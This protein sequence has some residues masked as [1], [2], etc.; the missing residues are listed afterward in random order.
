MQGD[1]SLIRGNAAKHFSTP[2]Q[3]QGRVT[4]DS[5]LNEG[6]LA[7]LHYLRTA[8][9]DIVGPSAVPA[10]P[11]GGF[12][13]GLPS[14]APA[15]PDLSISKGRMY[16]DGILIENENDTTYWTQ[17]DAYLDPATDDD[18]PTAPYLV[19]VRVWERLVTAA[20]DPSIREIALG[21]LAP[22]TAARLK[23]V[24]QVAAAAMTM[25]T[26]D[27]AQ[28]DKALDWLRTN[29][30]RVEATVPRM[31][32]RAQR[33][34][35]SDDDVCDITPDFRYRGAENQLYRVE[36]HTGGEAHALSVIAGKSQT[37]KAVGAGTTSGATYKVSRENASVALAVESIAGNTV[38]LADLGRDRKL[39]LEVGDWVEIVD[40]RYD[41][42]VDDD[43]PHTPTPALRRIAAIDPADRLVILEDATGATSGAGTDS[44][45]HPLLRRWDHRSTTRSDADPSLGV[46]SDGALPIVEGT[47]ID[48]EDGVQIFWQPAEGSEHRE[49][50]RGDYWWVPARTIGG[51]IVW[52]RDEN[53]EPEAHRPDGVAYHYAPLAYVPDD[54][55]TSLRP[56]IPTPHAPT[57]A[58]TVSPDVPTKPASPAASSLPATKT[59]AKKTTAKKTTAKKATA[60][61]AAAKK[62]PR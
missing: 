42:R 4:L 10:G 31:Q 59:A 45:L 26:D 50:R 38:R 60:K 1:F 17:P 7:F 12:E 61:K 14:P 34:E 53:G 32:A 33:P 28:I 37:A 46:R 54:S 16:V 11:A 52:P 29:R 56:E 36:V 5:D 41:L 20:Q 6:A 47:W 40:D 57:E 18:L 55:P 15:E 62:A 2:L 21:D 9:S 19:Y 51:D 24:W 23:V 3:Q 22:D 25:S 48:L 58:Q 44:T 13:I 43:V 35:D 8:V 27:N 30:L 39:A 49:Y